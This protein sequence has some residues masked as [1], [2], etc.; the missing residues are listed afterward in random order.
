[1]AFTF[2][3]AKEDILVIL[4]WKMINKNWLCKF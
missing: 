3:K 1:M 4:L 2:I